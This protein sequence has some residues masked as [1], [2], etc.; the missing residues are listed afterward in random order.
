MLAWSASRVTKAKG[1]GGCGGDIVRE[2]LR[3]RV[4]MEMVVRVK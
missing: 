3:G 4:E 1:L 2:R